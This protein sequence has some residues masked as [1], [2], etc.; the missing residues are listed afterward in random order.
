LADQTKRVHVRIA[1]VAYQLAATENEN[2]I[3]QMA[4]KAD[5][6]IRRV[7]QNSPQLSQNMA[8]VLALVNA[9]DEISQTSSQAEIAQ[10]QRDSLERQLAETK[11]ELSR[12]REQNWEMKKDM[13]KMQNLLAE[14]EHHLE[15]L[16]QSEIDTLGKPKP[17]VAVPEIIEDDDYENDENEEDG[18]LGEDFEP[19]DNLATQLID[20][21]PPSLQSYQQSC[22]EDFI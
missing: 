18:L 21:A 2:Y 3:R 20:T 12:M 22:L 17:V 1:N 15:K 13:L 5:E 8:T 7:Q 4:A 6:M 9:M 10:R 19:V 16:K 11:V 14:F